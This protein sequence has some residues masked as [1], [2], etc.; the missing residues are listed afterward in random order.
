MPK[1]REIARNLIFHEF[2]QGRNAVEAA[3]NICATKGRHYTT[4]RTCRRWFAKFR[5]GNT[6]RKDKSRSGRPPTL[7]KRA[8]RR[9]IESNPA[10]STRKLAAE[11][12]SSKSSIARHLHKLGKN[13]RRGQ[14]VPHELNETQ[15][16]RRISDC[17]WLLHKFSRGGL[18]RILTCDEKWVVYD[19]R[20]AGGQ[21]LSPGEV[22]LRTPRSDPHQKKLMLCV[23]WMASGVVHWELLPRGQTINSEVY[24]AQL[25]RVQ[26]KLQLRG[27]ATARVCLQ[28]DNARPHVSKQTLAKI[29][30]LGWDVLKH[31]PYSPDVAPSDYHL[32]RS[33]EHFLRG[34]RFTKDDDVRQALTDFF[35]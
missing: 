15:K 28:Q 31:P 19:N 16:N 2:K 33:L 11:L 17:N 5:S 13:S 30:E 26:A 29:E 1:N 9:S 22:G 20:K 6:H 27:I 7:D 32:F 14:E 24:C 3:Q 35:V 4:E 23:W 18:D 21:W 8:L 34:R 25:D 10:Q 12:H